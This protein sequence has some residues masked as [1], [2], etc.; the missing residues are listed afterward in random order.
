MKAKWC[1][2]PVHKCHS[3]IIVLLYIA[4]EW[5][6]PLLQELCW[7]S[8]FL[9]WVLHGGKV[10][11]ISWCLLPT[12]LR[13]RNVVPSVGNHCQLG[14]RECEVEGSFVTPILEIIHEWCMLCPHWKWPHHTLLSHQ[15]SYLNYEV[16]FCWFAIILGCSAE[17]PS[18]W[19]C[20]CICVPETDILT[21]T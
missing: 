16:I 4:Q 9:A 11:S 15:F 1:G 21:S 19:L 10:L 7:Q 8:N 14:G 18:R 2:F 12:S 5:T 3:W 20:Q 17:N 13:H 6:P